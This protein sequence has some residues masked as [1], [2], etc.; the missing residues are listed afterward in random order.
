MVCVLDL[1]INLTEDGRRWSEVVC[2]PW[3]LSLEVW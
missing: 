3:Q 2:V 1:E